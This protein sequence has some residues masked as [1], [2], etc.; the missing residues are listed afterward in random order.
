MVL[1]LTDCRQAMGAGMRLHLLDIPP[2]HI[3]QLILGWRMA[4]VVVDRVISL[5]R[6]INPD[7]KVIQAKIEKGQ[8][9]D[10]DCLYP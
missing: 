10:G 8:V 2:R 9:R 7:V 1:P 6:S 4:A 5:V 3:A